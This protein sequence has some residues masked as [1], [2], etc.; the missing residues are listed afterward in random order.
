M[1]KINDVLKNN[2]HQYDKRDRD[3]VDKGRLRVNDLIA[4]DALQID[5]NHIQVSDRLVRTIF[6]TGY[7]RT[8]HIGWLNRLYSYGENID[9]SI[10]IEPLGTERVIKSLNRKITQYTA[11]Q[12]MEAMKGK[13]SDV[14]VTSAKS[15]AEDLREKLHNGMEKLYY[16]AIY[17]NVSGKTEDELNEITEEIETMCGSIG[18]TTRQAIFQQEQGFITALPL[19]QDRINFRRNFDTSSLAT[20]LPIVSSELTMTEGTPILYG[21]NMINGSLVMFDRFKLNNYNSVTLAQSGKF[22]AP[23]NS[24][25]G[26][27]IL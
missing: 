9:I 16:Q 7:P 27:I 3:I 20:C 8:A 11:T 12:R 13:I 26:R 19:A 5:R 22:I 25:V 14:S 6:V 4:P 24:D 17:I 1:S 15:D 2:T 21:L 10:H 18:L 23:S